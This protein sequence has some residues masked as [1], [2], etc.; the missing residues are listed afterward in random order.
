[1]A[2]F[3]GGLFP[4]QGLVCNGKQICR[5]AVDLPHQLDNTGDL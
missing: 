3:G 1:M 2:E 4:A 5:W